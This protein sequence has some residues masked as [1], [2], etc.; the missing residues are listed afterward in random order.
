MKAHTYNIRQISFFLVLISATA[1]TTEGGSHFSIDPQTVQYDDA[2]V[3]DIVGNEAIVEPPN[4]YECFL[5]MIHNRSPEAENA[6][7]IAAAATDDV[8]VQRFVTAK[9][10]IDGLKEVI[11]N[12]PMQL[13]TAMNAFKRQMRDIR[14]IRDDERKKQEKEKALQKRN[15][16]YKEVGTKIKSLEQE[17]GAAEQEFQKAKQVLCRHARQQHR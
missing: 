2:H 9:Y 6:F 3:M 16:A 4:V 13:R 10:D 1:C 5:N 11:K 12:A 17:L 7:Y 14:K 8:I 15:K